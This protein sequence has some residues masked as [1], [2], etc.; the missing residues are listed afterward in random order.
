MRVSGYAGP[1][2]LPVTPRPVSVS[3]RRDENGGCLS[4]RCTYPVDP[5][6]RTYAWE[7]GVRP[8]RP[9]TRPPPSHDGSFDT[10]TYGPPRAHTDTRGHARGI[11]P[12][13]GFVGRG[14]GGRP[15]RPTDKRRQ[16]LPL[17]VERGDL[18]SATRRVEVVP[19]QGAPWKTVFRVPSPSSL[20]RPHRDTPKRAERN[21][22]GE[23]EE[24][25]AGRSRS[26]GLGGRPKRQVRGYLPRPPR[27]V[28]VVSHG[29]RPVWDARP[30][31]EVTGLSIEKGS[32][33]GTPEIPHFNPLEGL[34]RKGP[35]GH[36][37]LLSPRIGLVC[38]L[39]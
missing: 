26:D 12:G 25:G 32:D 37:K 9:Q 28:V 1:G 19:R 22:K 6:R 31:T 29:N 4:G 34:K 36:S 20:L 5:R 13:T 18:V 39:F 2:H 38:D 8:F 17:G 24:T 21:G 11:G 33:L 27:T 15:V 14:T 7:S 35:T 16:P 23:E 30:A 10:D 3:R